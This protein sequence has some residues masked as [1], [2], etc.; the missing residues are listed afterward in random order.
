MAND[1]MPF[2]SHPS[3]YPRQ[4]LMYRAFEAREG[5]CGSLTQGSHDPH[6]FQAY[7]SLFSI[8]KA[9]TFPDFTRHSFS[10]LADSVDAFVIVILNR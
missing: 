3:H 7:P 9:L 4:T 8:S 5:C 2:W 10:S 1:L 6:I